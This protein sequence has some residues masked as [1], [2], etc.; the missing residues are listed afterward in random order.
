MR[1]GWA[2]A[3]LTVTLAGCSGAAGTP[4]A[5]LSSSI[6]SAPAPTAPASTAPAS[7]ASS[8]TVPTTTRST[9]P[10]STSTPPPLT[11]SIPATTSLT[12]TPTPSSRSTLTASPSPS[13]S[14][15]AAA[16]SSPTSKATG[17]SL[18]AVGLAGVNDPDCRSADPPVLLLHG[19][20]STPRSNFGTLAPA[21]RAAGRCVYA[22]EYGARFGYG[23]IG[24]IRTSAADVATFARRV[25]EV[26][27][28]D[29]LD[30]VGYSQG[31]LVVRTMLRYDLDPGLV[32]VAVLVA[33]S[34]HGTT[35]PVTTN[36][37]SGLCPACE[38]Q[39]VGSPLLTDLATGGDLAG[40]VRYA[41]LS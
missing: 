7:T 9:S 39:T 5:M 2:L 22:L 11:T 1:F 29:Q 41:V 13:P 35:S 30:V 6:V 36:I 37:P 10:P 12:P 19:T 15:N 26:T 14:P 16:T 31:G 21:L 40:N 24:P 32:R 18:P 20:L 38:D 3:A 27:G 23:G 33:P 34:Y 8:I 4:T 28:A 25:L 17:T